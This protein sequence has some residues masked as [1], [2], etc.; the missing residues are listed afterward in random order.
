MS[1]EQNPSQEGTSEVNATK[2]AERVVVM[3]GD[4]QV[5]SQVGLHLLAELADRSGLTSAYSAAVPWTG[6]RAPGHDR[7]RLLAQVAVMLAG[8][9][10]CVS[11]L[12]ALR[13][14]PALFG[15]VA[16]APTAWRALHGIDGAVLDA[17]RRGRAQARAKV[18]AD[19]AA[20]EEVILDVD[21]A[22]VELHSANKEGAASHFKGGFGFHPMFCFLDASGEALAGLLRAGNAT[23]NSA[24]DQLAVVDAAMEQLPG[25]YQAGHRAGDDAAAV[26]HRVVVRADSAGAVSGLVAALVARNIEFSVYARVN[27]ALHQA[28]SAVAPDAWA[29][30]VDDEGEPRHAGEV[31]ELDVV[32][33]GWPAGTR[34]ICRREQ[35][36]PGAQLRLWDADGWRH[37][38]ILT[39]SE[40]DALSLE[41]RQR[42]HARVENSIK[43]L[44]DTGLDRM[45]FTSFAANAAWLE[46]VLAGGDLLAWLRLVCVDGEL[47]RAE[48]KALRYR[49][50]H[51]AAR[52]VRRARQLVLRLPTHWPWASELAGAYRRL[53]LLCT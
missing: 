10:E 47:A 14:Q 17:L 21:A 9:G 15:E 42:R 31:A 37:Q 11:D 19:G 2:A 23:A 30:A 49:L 34:A 45:P 40:G 1:T 4:N 20:P 27:N 32:L 53:A 8:G 3:E 41:L 38:V 36:H 29:R 5:A 6:E 33:D 28:I 44:R 22:L 52:L 51:T 7:G 25:E 24:A 43:A 50:L 16:S 18:W 13:D 35:P 12:A 26:A 39:N 48:P 46:L